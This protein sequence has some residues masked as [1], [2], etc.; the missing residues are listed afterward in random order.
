VRT[1]L[2]GPLGGLMT[3]HLTLRRSL[4]YL[5]RTDEM[6]L[7]DFDAYVGEHF[8]DATGV[9]RSMVTGYFKTLSDQQIVTKRK[10][11]ATIRQF[12]RFLFQMNPETYIPEPYLLPAGTSPFQPHLYTLAEV[13]DLMKVAL[14]LPPEGSLR[15]HTYSTLIG[16][17]WA[18]GLRGGEAVRLNLEDVDLEKGILHIRQTKNCKS[19]LV[20]LVDSTRVAL[21]VYCELRSR[22]GLDQDRQAPFF[23]N[24]RKVRC[25]HRTVDSTFRMLTR[26]L[27][28]MSVYGREPRLHDLRHTW[29]TR[30]LARLYEAG[31][32]PNA[33]LPVLATYLG[34]MNIACTT[35]YLHP[36]EDLLVQA[37][38]RFQDYVETV[39]SARSGGQHD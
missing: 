27:G 32:D 10:R 38:H 2:T 24:E 7:D 8:P 11:L 14:R 15:P 36:A 12:C 20:P 31:Q 21:T 29:A 35:V 30:C 9:T 23:V 33:M 13:N 16:L 37:G 19:R 6:A 17:L 22:L 3:Q 39:E 18:S 25:A 1:Q 5:L 28:L 26:E 34:H 4:G